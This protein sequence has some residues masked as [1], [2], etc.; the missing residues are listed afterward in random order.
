[1]AESQCRWF[2]LDFSGTRACEASSGPISPFL[3]TGTGLLG[4]RMEMHGNRVETCG[5]GTLQ[6]C[7]HMLLVIGMTVFAN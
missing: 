6:F 3:N 1:M 5:L 2:G 4:S 7:L